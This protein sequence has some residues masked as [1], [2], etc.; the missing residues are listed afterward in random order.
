MTAEL[1][2]EE[3]IGGQ[4]FV[5]VGWHPHINRHGHPA[6]VIQ[7]GSHCADCGASFQATTIP[8]RLPEVR[9]CSAHHAP[10]KRVTPSMEPQA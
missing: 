3:I 4:R 6:V 8:G 9:R 5:C 10:G 7:W 1:F 2:H